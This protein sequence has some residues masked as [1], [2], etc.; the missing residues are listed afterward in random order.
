MSLANEANGILAAAAPDPG[1]IPGTT[2][3]VVTDITFGGVI[4][5]GGRGDAPSVVVNLSYAEDIVSQIASVTVYLQSP[6][7]EVLTRSADVSDDED[8]EA[9]EVRLSAQSVSGEYA[10]QQVIVQFEGDPDVTGLPANGLTLLADEVSSLIDGRFINIENAD[11]DI[12]PPDIT[13]ILLPTRSILVDNDLPLVLGGGDSAEITFEATIT[14]DNSGLN[15]IEFEFDIGEGFAA[16]IGAEVG[17]FGDLDEGEQQ[18]SAFNTESP[19]GRYIF[20]LFRVSD[21][22]G[23]TTVYTAD[24][25]AGLG[26][27][28]AIQVVT[29][30]TWRTRPAPPLTVLHSHQT[31]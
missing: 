19:A 15:V 27:Q 28:N 29:P 24:D 26:F 6:N 30:K 13:D 31:Q 22:Q 8:I 11:E 10:I 2:T 1:A 21:D 14:D 18:L 9:I 4:D 25:L 16:V 17:V 23:N 7:G 3:S 20:E 12:T 5:G